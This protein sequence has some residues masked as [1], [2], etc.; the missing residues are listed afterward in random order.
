VCGGGRIGC[1]WLVERVCAKLGVSACWY[2]FQQNTCPPLCR[3]SGT[4]PFFVV[5]TRAESGE[6][7]Q[8]EKS[9]HILNDNNP[10]VNWSVQSL[11]TDGVASIFIAVYDNDNFSADDFIGQLQFKLSDLVGETVS[12]WH[13][14]KTKTGEEDSSLGEV[15]LS[16]AYAE[17]LIGDVSAEEGK[18]EGEED[19]DSKE[20]EP[21]AE[22]KDGD[23]EPEP[24]AEVKEEGDK[25][26]EPAAEVK[27]EGDKEPEPAA[28]VKEEGDKEPE[29]AAEVKE[30][31]DK[32]PEPAAEVKEEGDKEP[33]PAAEVKEEGGK[34]PEPVSEAKDGENKNAEPA[35][36]VKEEG[37]NEPEPAAEVKEEGDKETEPSAEANDNENKNAEPAAAEVKEEGNKGLEPASEAK[38]NENKEAEPTAE[39]AA[40]EP[41]VF[42]VVRKEIRA[43]SKEEQ[44]RWAAAVLKMMENKDGV[45]GTSE[46]FRIAG[47]HGWPSKYCA[48]R[49]ETFPAW[50]RAYLCEMEKALQQADIANGNDGQI[51]FP[52][53]DWMDIDG[54]EVMPSIVAD[55]I[56]ALPDDFFSEEHKENNKLVD[57]G[58]KRYPLDR[59]KRNLKK[60]NLNEQVYEALEEPQHWKAASTAGRAGNVE[61]PHN[62][63]HVALGFPMSTVKYAAF[64]PMFWLHHCNVDRLYESYIAV[65]PDSKAEFEASAT[66]MKEQ[67]GINPSQYEATLAP[68]QHPLH[69]ESFVPEHSFSTEKLGFKYDALIQPRPKQL[70]ALPT[71]ALFENINVMDLN[72]KS[73]MLFIFVIPK[74]EVESWTAPTDDFDEHPNY[75]GMATT[76]GGKE[77]C[78]NCEENPFMWSRVDIS[79]ALKRLDVSRYDAAIRVVC[80][81]E[82]GEIIPFEETKL[83]EPIVTGP[84]FESSDK[85]IVAVNSKEEFEGQALP[86]KGEVLQ[87]QRLLT[88]FGY[89]SGSID[90]WFGSNTDEALKAYQTAHGLKTDAIAGPI[91]KAALL[92]LRMDGLKDGFKEEG[93]AK[94][95]WKGKDGLI[96]FWV[97]TSPG[98]LNREA[99]LSD[100]QAAVDQWGAAVSMKMERTEESAGADLVLEWVEASAE[101]KF[102]FD[103][104]DGNLA[105]AM[106]SV[107]EGPAR[108]E[109]DFA[110]KWLTTGS[111]S[112]EGYFLLPVTLHE[113]GHIMGL[114]HSEDSHAVMAPYYVEDS[115]KLSA[116]DITA[117][118]KLYG[119]V[120]D[121]SVEEGAQTTEE[122][123]AAAA[124]ENAGQ[125]RNYSEKEQGDIQKIQALA[126]GNLARKKV[127]ALREEKQ[128]IEIPANLESKTS[129]DRSVLAAAVQAAGSSLTAASATEAMQSTGL[130]KEKAAEHVKEYC[131]FRK[132]DRAGSFDA[133][134]F[135]AEYTRMCR[136]K[137]VRSLFKQAKTTG[138]TSFVKEEVVAAFVM[139]LGDASGKD[140]AEQIAYPCTYEDVFSWYNST[141]QK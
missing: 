66:M 72:Y 65:H 38:D 7:L 13:T 105:H 91:T 116:K 109:F 117:V 22:V 115:C 102:K 69:N 4:D 55:K 23:K 10:E 78:P 15:E 58:Y 135:L 50:H 41:E 27:E 104:K 112:K 44:E 133:A 73:Y 16:L 83:P 82:V 138:Q 88:R 101:Q 1:D 51:G 57:R 19:G 59:I 140:D 129:Y 71:F 77:S 98:S 84:H 121:A 80:Q 127:Q 48:H 36:E 76:F 53:W 119:V 79:A 31:G 42:V 20:P 124:D 52:Y 86:D 81:D 141:V 94:W 125:P 35:A 40:P 110:D 120:Q 24:A 32:E 92:K 33:A 136:F 111:D 21:A 62:S 128:K 11:K 14:L 18:K 134:E 132:I 108:I 34:E 70:R 87:L 2:V 139:F 60:A 56:P 95:K 29:P 49:K 99:V 113:M 103:G 46:W 85:S 107:A 8:T 126:K 28:E 118:Q 114:P 39:V 96:K 12:G 30:E 3:R 9:E 67:R 6:T 100:I 74:G 68:F 61:S 90:G 93:E 122:P 123:A 75:A 130:S 97:G 43:M 63:V 5:Q 45:A 89:Y 37:D 54:E 137:A 26:P 17:P 47:Y 25:E 106:D 131:I 64:D